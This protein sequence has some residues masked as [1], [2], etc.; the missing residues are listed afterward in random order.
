MNPLEKEV[1]MNIHPRPFFKVAAGKAAFFFL[2]WLCCLA[3]APGELQADQSPSWPHEKCD[4]VPDPALTFGRLPN[5]IRYVLMENPKPKG[6]V[7]IHLNIQAGSFH[8]TD[9]QKGLAHFLEHLLFNGTEHFPPGELVKYF[10]RIGMRFGP[11]ANA[12]TGFFETVY[13]VL[14][15]DNSSESIKEG[16]LVLW[17]YAAGALL[18]PEEIDRERKVVL[19]EKRTRDSVSYRTF[20]ETLKF[21]LPGTR[22]ADR[23]P[24]GETAVLEAADRQE[25]KAYY[26]AWYRP[27]NIILVLAGDFKTEQIVP[28]IE[29]RF[30][31]MKARA[32]KPPDPAPVTFEHKGVKPFY[33]HEPEAGNTQLDIEVVAPTGFQP[34]SFDFQKQQLL[35]DLSHSIVQNRLDT[36]LKTPDAPFTSARVGAGVYLNSVSYAAISAECAPDQWEASLAAIEQTL[37]KALEHGF[38]DGEIDRVKK[39]WL[40]SLDNEVKSAETRD[41]TDLARQI[42]RH[43][44]ADRVFQSPE[45]ER[46]LYGPVIRNV[47]ADD[48]HQAFKEAWAQDHRLV[49]ATGNLDIQNTPESRIRDAYEK[50]RA[51]PVS[52]PAEEKTAEF[53]YLDPPDALGKIVSENKIDDPDIFQIDFENRLR[54]NIKPTDF[55]ANTVVARLSFGPGLAAE[56]PDK[57]GLAHLTQAVVNESG[58]GT[59]DKDQ[60]EQAL[61]G[62]ETSVRF[63]VSEDRF[64]FQARAVSNELPLLFQLLHA[65]LTDP[66]FREQAFMLSMKRFQQRHLALSRT[67]DGAVLLKGKRFLAGGDSRFGLPPMADFEKLTLS[68]AQTWLTPY[69]SN[70]PLELSIVGDMEPDRVKKLARTYLGGLPRG[71]AMHCVSTAQPSR[72]PDFPEGKTLGL[73]VDTEI[74]KGLVIVA[75]PTDDIWDIHKTRRL[76]ALAGVFNDRLRE[77]I[78]EELGATYSPTAYNDPSRAYDGYGV[79]QAIVQLAPE[80][81][82]A[83]IKAVKDITADICKNGV[84]EDEIRRAVDPTL[85]SIRDMRQENRYWLSTVLDGSRDHPEQIQ[86]SRTIERD[87]ASITVKDI[88]EMAMQYLDNKRSAVVVVAPETIIPESSKIGDVK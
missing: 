79:F 65:H 56:P 37:R 45:Q 38:T 44:N 8:E 25:L 83:V 67:V 43:L 84:S 42:I 15:P 68:D 61:A 20:V 5:G 24:I 40:A 73:E 77:T 78:R 30:S 27:D 13:D 50:S 82:E 66:G 16:L 18:L 21:E 9:E 28:L 55:E 74:P 47:S 26:D 54:V 12:H 51:V 32:V 31:D 59:L 49:L 19:A 41:S 11:D 48:L 29:K 80:Q 75:Y 87:Y 58:L 36:L 4:L 63:G 46:N 57:P 22:L 52:P 2:I 35:W 1:F 33:H 14:L 23:L 64:Y 39:D 81:A 34:D 17:D 88:H 71:D 70:A 6:R 7:S 85:T 10:Q 69:L 86:W 72:L 76:S 60:L 3:A 62:K 53:P